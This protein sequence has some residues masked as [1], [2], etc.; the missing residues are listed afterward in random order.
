MKAIRFLASA[1]LLYLA[2][3]QPAFANPGT[4]VPYG[5]PLMTAFMMISI[6]MLTAIGGGYTVLKA[7]REGKPPERAAIITAVIALYVVS[8]FGQ[9]QMIGAISIVALWG[10]VRGIRMLW[11]AYQARKGQERSPHLAAAKPWRLSVCGVLLIVLML[12][13]SAM[14]ITVLLNPV[15]WRVKASNAAALSDLRNTHAC[16]DAYYK[17]HHAYPASREA[18][19]CG[20]LSSRVTLVIEKDGYLYAQ[21][22]AGDKEYRCNVKTGSIAWKKRYDLDEEWEQE[23]TQ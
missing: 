2:M 16:F 20:P 7:L 10:A 13:L 5:M 4:G 17:T 12:L 3:A 19:N 14:S 23:P 1:P 9:Y 21:H 6:L 11:W 22:E 18:G 8:H 15:N